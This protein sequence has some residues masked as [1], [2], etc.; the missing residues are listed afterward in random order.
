M[1][2]GFVNL[3]GCMVKLKKI[4][5]FGE[6]KYFRLL[7]KVLGYHYQIDIGFS[8]DSSHPKKYRAEP[9]RQ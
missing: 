4:I 5:V 8:T 9:M 6:I 1:M 7:A 3:E 2:T